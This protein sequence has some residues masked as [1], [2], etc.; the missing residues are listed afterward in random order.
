M[1]VMTHTQPMHQPR[2]STQSA[3]GGDLRGEAGAQRADPEL[4]AERFA[5]SAVKTWRLSSKSKSDMS[6]GG[7]V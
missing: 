4:A 2:D 6:R 7:P 5:H 1:R 3:A